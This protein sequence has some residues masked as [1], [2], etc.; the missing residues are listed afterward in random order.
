MPDSRDLHSILLDTLD[1]AVVVLDGAGSIVRVNRRVSDLWGY[2]ERELLG[3]KLS[4]LVSSESRETRFGAAANGGA[5]RRALEAYR[6]DGTSFPVDVQ[7]TKEVLDGR[8]TTLVTVRDLTDLRSA[9][10][11]LRQFE[12]ALET[13]Q[14]GVAMTNREQ[15]IF[16]AN[17]ALA[18]M[19]GY[20]IRELMGRSAALL[21]P[22]EMRGLLEFRELKQIKTFKHESFNVRRDGTTFPVELMSDLV[23]TADGDPV[24]IVTICQ[25][26]TERKQAEEALRVSEER[27][28]LA[29]RGANDGLWDWNLESG[30]MYF[31]PRWKVM[32]GRQEAEIEPSKEEWFSRVHPED[33]PRLEAKLGRHLAGQSQHFEDEHRMLHRDGSYHWMLARGLAVWDDTGRATRMAGSLSDI[34]D[35]KVHDPLTGLPNRALYLDRL[36]GALARARRREGQH[37]AVLFLDL[38]RFKVVNDSLGHLTGDQLLVAIARRLESSLPPGD[39]VAR[40]GG[41]EFTILVENAGSVTEV[42]GLAERLH[43]E[44]SRPFG[45]EGQELFSSASIGIAYAITGEETAEDLLRDA[46]AAMYRAK[47]ERRG[48]HQVFDLEMRT[49]ALAQL[50]LET[51]LRRAVERHELVT[52]YQPIFS[53]ASDQI[54]GFESLVR[55]QHP[56][57]GLLEP[58]EFIKTAEETGLIV[59]VSRWVLSDACETLYRWR[60]ELPD[61]P[62]TMNVNLSPRQF[63]FA[64]LVEEVRRRIEASG[65]DPRAIKLEITE[66]ALVAHPESASSMLAALRE[67]G[68]TICIDDFGTGYSSLSYLHQFPIDTLKIDRIFISQLG[69]VQQRTGLVRSIIRLAADLGLDVVAEG[70]ETELQL[71]E[72]RELRCGYVQ[73]YLISRP[74]PAE[75]A[76]ALLDNPPI[77]VTAPPPRRA[78]RQT[79][80]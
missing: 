12:K 36:D 48:R 27:Y 44:L 5:H 56:E 29:V 47:S 59:P 10:D 22:E 45:L 80:H 25:D 19:H 15:R 23:T 58:A 38:D 42:M 66:T 73:G 49:G 50:R 1:E 7:M 2:S 28:A 57:R 31:S 60:Q 53:L 40:L 18:D 20:S 63:Q 4:L 33:L 37:V 16:Y 17:P 43:E 32:L 30:E 3:K 55:W 39:T 9:Q 14:L 79:Q 75:A 24:G 64:D 74:L 78:R 72:L 77:P 61:R 69:E 26:I 70:V 41:D 21:A 6:R 8:P 13:M 52:Y 71:R 51:D 65:V 76:R 67:I 62:L 46:D 54:V 35:R 68:L 34:T 11:R